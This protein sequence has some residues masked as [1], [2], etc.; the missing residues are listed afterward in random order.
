MGN[1]LPLRPIHTQV[2]LL[3]QFAPEG[4]YAPPG[5]VE[6]YG[7]VAQVMKEYIMSAGER[8]EDN[9]FTAAEFEDLFA[10]GFKT[11]HSMPEARKATAAA[12]QAEFALEEA[13]HEFFTNPMVCLKDRPAQHAEMAMAA[14][15]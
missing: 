15:G 14:H 4:R 7:A 6:I 12:N 9:P 10:I 13:R 1:T 3:D 5:S 11:L 2:R 8:Y